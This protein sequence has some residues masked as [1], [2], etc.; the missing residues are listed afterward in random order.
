MSEQIT[1][2]LP[3]GLEVDGKTH[4]VGKMHLTT[5]I[6]ELNIQENE[7]VSFNS[8]YRDILL[9]A[10]VID[11]IGEITNVTKEI[12]T[13]PKLENAMINYC[14]KTIEPKADDSGINIYDT[15]TN[16][17]LPFRVFCFDNPT[18]DSLKV[19]FDINFE[20]L[21]IFAFIMIV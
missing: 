12:D 9:L 2:Y 14:K 3:L 17:D 1:F 16:K 4:R 8:R 10:S 5:T 13:V 7:D 18:N 11:E 20:G 19:K 21:N 15:D 6:D